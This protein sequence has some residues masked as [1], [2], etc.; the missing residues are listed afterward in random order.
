MKAANSSEHTATA[1]REPAIP[2]RPRSSKVTKEAILEAA[3]AEFAKLGYEGTTTAAIAR[4]VGVTQPLIHYHF[5][6]KDELW[7][8]TLDLAFSRLGARLDKLSRPAADRDAFES[9]ARGYIEFVTK[10]PEFG[11]M[12]ARESDPERIRWMV[13]RY[14]RPLMQ[15]L[16]ARLDEA[17]AA[18]YLAEI[19]TRH[20]LSA[21]IGAAN[22]PFN[23][24]SIFE[25]LYGVDPRSPDE[26]VGYASALWQIMT[27][28]VVAA[29]E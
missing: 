26:A 17:K 29:D 9:L 3:F 15:A 16:E 13:D 10:H 2:G 25:E 12:V 19:P 18:G 8:Q 11:R 21:F 5:G 20:I 6:S 4:R 23:M 14:I 1:N 24:T 22:H 28:G 27:G 7:R